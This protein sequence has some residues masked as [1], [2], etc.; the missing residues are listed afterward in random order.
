MLGE[1]F[2]FIDAIGMKQRQDEQIELFVAMMVRLQ[3][4]AREKFD[5]PLVVIYSWP[6]EKSRTAC[7][8]IRSSTSPCWS[9]SSRG[10]ASSASR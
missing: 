7:T 4:Y 2:A 6:D 10:C 3:Q 1:H 8:A 5:A 9:T